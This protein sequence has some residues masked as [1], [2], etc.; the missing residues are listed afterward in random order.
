MLQTDIGL[1]YAVWTGEAEVTSTR[2]QQNNS[3]GN[4]ANTITFSQT[5][6]VL[7]SKGNTA[8]GTRQWLKIR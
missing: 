2:F 4:A 7:Q 5:G 3:V 8:S 1:A 6:A